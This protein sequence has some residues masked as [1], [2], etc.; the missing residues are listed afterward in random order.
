[1]ATNLRLRPETENALRDESERSGRSQQDLMREAIDQYL[2]LS[3]REGAIPG[4]IESLIAQG[5][6]IPPTM[7]Y[8][9]AENPFVPSDGLTSEELIERDREDRF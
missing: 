1:M 4:S 6:L 3:R 7:P 8:R 2:G 9:R 5:V